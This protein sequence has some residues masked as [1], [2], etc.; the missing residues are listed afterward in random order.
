MDGRIS[1]SAPDRKACRALCQSVQEPGDCAME[2][3]LG[4][5]IRC[6]VFSDTPEGF[7]SA[8]SAF[9]KMQGSSG[10]SQ[11]LWIALYDW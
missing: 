2:V 11:A 6:F 1:E 9:P 5:N 3:V 10:G 8:A 4:G 7:L